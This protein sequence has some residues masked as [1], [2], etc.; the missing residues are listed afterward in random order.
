VSGCEG[1]G[2]GVS[3]EC[4]E[5]V[6]VFVSE[7]VA[8]GR[9]GLHRVACIACCTHCC[10]NTHTSSQFGFNVCKINVDGGQLN[11]ID[12]SFTLQLHYSLGRKSGVCKRPLRSPKEQLNVTDISFPLIFLYTAGRRSGYLNVPSDFR[13]FSSGLRGPQT[14]EPRTKKPKFRIPNVHNVRRISVC[15]AELCDVPPRI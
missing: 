4:V 3:D 14:P 9:C 5:H 15:N 6:C 7:H 2:A 1:E 10:T 13:K 8:R 11:V 12:I